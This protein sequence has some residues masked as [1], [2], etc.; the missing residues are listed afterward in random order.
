MIPRDPSRFRVASHGSALA[1][2]VTMQCGSPVGPGARGLRPVSSP[3]AAF[4][5]SISV[6]AP[7]GSATGSGTASA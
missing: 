4:R 3:Q 7:Q 1:R 6:S 2:S 5:H